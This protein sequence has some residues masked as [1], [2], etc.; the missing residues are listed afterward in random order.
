MSSMTSPSDYKGTPSTV[1]DSA[2]V[3]KLL[4]LPCTESS[5]PG[6]ITIR[7][8]RWL[9]DNL[10]CSMLGRYVLAHLT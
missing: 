6:G 7:E 3:P 4:P 1:A 9:V 2:I 8:F 10:V 5:G